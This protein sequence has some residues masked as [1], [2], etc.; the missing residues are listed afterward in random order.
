MARGG[1]RTGTPGKP[2]PNRADLRG[3]PSIPSVPQ[4][5]PYGAVK[6]Q[7]AVV[8]STPAQPMPGAQPPT[9]RPPVMPGSLGAFNRPTERPDIPITNGLA[10][11]PGAGPEALGAGLEAQDPVV[12]RL[13]ALYQ[14]FPSSE[15]ADLLDEII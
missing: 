6:A 2:Y 13:K 3:A 1:K 12:L 7:E 11:G 9:G 14:M 8:A 10:T 4:G 5:Q 15:L